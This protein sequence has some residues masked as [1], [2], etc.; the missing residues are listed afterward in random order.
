MEAFTSL[1]AIDTLM[2]LQKATDIN[3]LQ[4]LK[5]IRPSQRTIQRVLVKI[6][7]RPYYMKDIFAFFS[8]YGGLSLKQLLEIMNRT[9]MNISKTS[10]SPVSSNEY[11]IYGNIYTVL[12]VF[13][14]DVDIES[15]Q[16]TNIKTIDEINEKYKLFSMEENRLGCLYSLRIHEKHNFDI[17]NVE[18]FLRTS[19]ITLLKG[20]ILN[21]GWFAMAAISLVKESQ[22]FHAICGGGMTILSAVTKW[23]VQQLLNRPRLI[24]SKKEKKPSLKIGEEKIL[25]HISVKSSQDSKI[26][27]VM[28]LNHIL[29][30]SSKCDGGSS[31][32][33]KRPF[34][35]EED[36]ED[37]EDVKRL[38]FSIDERKKH[39]LSKDD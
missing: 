37:S 5:C 8:S 27:R 17:C 22:N 28:S 32:V 19:Q 35:I 39:S 24:R 36:A 26:E 10:T 20:Q 15:K 6:K 21:C 33:K 9:F 12:L 30:E 18:A 2:S 16:D 31:C 7:C 34:L 25:N 29:I 1:D 11:Q 4:K 3:V 14:L 38:R 13:I 23:I